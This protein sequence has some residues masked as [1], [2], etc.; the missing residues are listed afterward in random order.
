MHDKFLMVE[1]KRLVFRVHAIRRMFERN[2]TAEEIRRV[3]ENGEVI[4]EYPHDEPYPSFLVLGW[5]ENAPLHVVV[6]K[7]GAAN[8]G[9]IITVYRPDPESWTEDFKRRRE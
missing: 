8:T 3:V 4:E 2:I 1:V 5:I 7:E 9:V 6:A